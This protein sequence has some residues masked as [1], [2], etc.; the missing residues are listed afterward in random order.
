MLNQANDIFQLIR[1]KQWV[2]NVFVFI[3]MFFGR[4]FFIQGNIYIAILVFFS[5]SFISSAVYCINDIKDLAYDKL[6]PIKK[7]RPLA[8]GKL[9]VKTSY[10]CAFIMFVLSQIMA[11]IVGLKELFFVINLYLILNLLYSNF[12]KH[13]AFVDLVIIS[14][15]FLLRLL[16]GAITTEIVLSKWIILMVFLLTMFLGLGKRK[17]E[18]MLLLKTNK[19]SRANLNKFSL[20]NINILLKI[21]IVII[22]LAYLFYTLT[23]NIVKYNNNNYTVFTTIFVI[24]GLIRYYKIIDLNLEYGNP[25]K[26]VWKDKPIQIILLAWILSYYLILYGI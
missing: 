4:E 1:V 23:S 5:F 16:V 21:L 19:K 25:T 9:T 20:I 3:P 7:N 17:G 11:Y 2:K 8:S 14:I 15:G 12:L 6:H 26:I 10:I 13:L 18:V 24:F 22:T